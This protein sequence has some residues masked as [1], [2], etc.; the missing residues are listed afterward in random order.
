MIAAHAGGWFLWKGSGRAPRLGHA[1]AFLGTLV[2]GANVGLVAQIFHVSGPWWRGFGLFAAGALAAGLAYRSLPHHLLASAL[3]LG[4][5]GA[6]FGSEHPAAGLALAYAL[7]ALFGVAA[8]RVPSRALAVVTALGAAFMLAAIV[9]GARGEEA[10]PLALAALAAA[11]AGAPLA[12]RGARGEHVAPAL[13][14]VGRVGFYLAAYALSFGDFADAQRIAEWSGY[15]LAAVVPALAVAAALLA[16]GLGRADVDAL[17]RGEAMLL[18][19]TVVAFALGQGLS[20]GTGTTIVANMALVFLAVGRIVRGLSWLRRGP[21]WEGMALAGVVVTSRFFE[22]D[23][24]LWLKGAAFIACGV[25]VMAAGFAFER[26]RA[27][28]PEGADVHPA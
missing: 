27:H 1:L 6:G 20:S 7:A 19:G 8:W 12:A 3:A 5:F 13:R 2:F 25:A 9:A 22:L 15:V 23:T 17:A 18:V 14:V 11:C 28:A 26:R 4:V 16:S 21:F 24:E 10:V